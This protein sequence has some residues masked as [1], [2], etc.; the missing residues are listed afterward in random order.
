MDFIVLPT[1]ALC[2]S[3]PSPFVLGKQTKHAVIL[4]AEV[5][6]GNH[7]EQ[8]LREDDMPILVFVVGVSV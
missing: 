8:L 5:F 1:Q 7:L 2:N 6:F 3:D 4:G